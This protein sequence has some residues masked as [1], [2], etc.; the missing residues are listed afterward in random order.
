MSGA[1]AIAAF[2]LAVLV[3][4]AAAGPESPPPPWFVVA[5]IPG[6]DPAIAETRWLWNREA[7]TLRYCRQDAATGA[8]ACASDVVMPDGRWVLQR[9][10]AQPSDD[11]AASARFYSPDRDQTLICTATTAG[12]FGCE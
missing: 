8:F 6:K 7:R 4:G 12:G 11:V 2:G 3:Q 10:Q 5:D 1:L 9:L